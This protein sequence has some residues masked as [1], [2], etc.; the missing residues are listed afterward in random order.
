MAVT[1]NDC[2]GEGKASS[3]LMTP[4]KSH[5]WVVHNTFVQ[6]PSEEDEPPRSHPL[7]R[8]RSTPERRPERLD[9]DEEFNSQVEEM[10]LLE[11]PVAAYPDA[12][13]F[14]DSDTAPVEEQSVSDAKEHKSFISV[15][16]PPKQLK[17]P[18]GK[19]QEPKQ[20]QQQNPAKARTEAAGRTAATRNRVEDRPAGKER[21]WEASPRT[22]KANKPPNNSGPNQ[23]SETALREGCG[24][25][26]L[27]QKSAATALN[28]QSH[29]SPSGAM[30]QESEQQ[31]Q[32]QQQQAGP[33]PPMAVLGQQQHGHSMGM[34]APPMSPPNMAS[35]PWCP[36][37]MMCP[38]HPMMWGPACFGPG[39]TGLPQQQDK[40]EGG[41]HPY[42]WPP[43]AQ[44]WMPPSQEQWPQVAMQ[45]SS[46]THMANPAALQM[47]A[48][49]AAIAGGV[50]GC[51]MLQPGLQLPPQPPEPR[52]TDFISS[53]PGILVE[54]PASS[55][56]QGSAPSQGVLWKVDGK[57]LTQNNKQ[58][59]SPDFRMTF[60]DG[61][62]R[63]EVV[64]KLILYP[65]ASVNGNMRGGGSFKKTRGR[66]YVQ[67]K[68]DSVLT[69]AAQANVSFSIGIGPPTVESA[70][71]MR[72]PVH[73]NFAQSAVC[74]LE[75][76]EEDWD[77]QAAVDETGTFGV[78]LEIAMGQVKP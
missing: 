53:N 78:S 2:S 55:A 44:P 50:A 47:C 26:G 13:D 14:P 56:L 33:W 36:P 49:G 76:M 4:M 22:F 9:A 63:K 21:Q 11:L 58:A 41:L 72:G 6:I 65:R 23:S 16:T 12:E 62:S 5:N 20:Q 74:G 46:N 42:F 54:R 40:Q 34:V 67:L 43:Q 68:C 48:P 51:G 19:Q 66:G 30:F 39:V 28:L 60:C 70:H 59:V 52:I 35:H 38:P 31:Q 57:K 64:F 37:P 77:F 32:Q 27:H 8:A 29:M 73:H 69:D 3:P 45:M 1:D 18:H 75:K 10:E 17:E 71:D 15:A 61:Q 7:R 24:V 25:G